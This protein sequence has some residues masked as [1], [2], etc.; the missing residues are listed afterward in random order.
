GSHGLRA[1]RRESGTPRRFHGDDGGSRKSPLEPLRGL[2]FPRA[3][4]D[5][6]PRSFCRRPVLL[7]VPLAFFAEKG[8]SRS[9]SRVRWLIAGPLTAL[10]LAV[11]GAQS[12]PGPITLEA[13]V[14]V[15]SVTVVV[16]DKA[17]HFVHGLG[18]G[19]IE[20]LE[21]GVPQKVSYFREA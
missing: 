12:P 18:P 17:G 4:R 10:A 13:S 16:F 19:D 14:D 11:I 20:V 8:D 9:R 6:D 21:D 2:F 3:L 7:H 5:R 15:V 1:P